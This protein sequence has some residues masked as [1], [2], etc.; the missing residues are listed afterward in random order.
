MLRKSLAMVLALITVSPAVAADVK[1]SSTLAGSP[2][3]DPDGAGMASF[4]IDAASGKVCYTLEVS[5]IDTA[6]A[7]HIHK[8]A[9]G[10][11]GPPVVPLDAPAN[12]K[13]Q[14]CAT[15]SPDVAAAIVADPSGYYVNVHNKAFMGGAIRGQLSK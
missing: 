8:G 12:G 3:T 5:N 13:S 1:L 14:G 10:A 6:L 4:T 7:A 11:G 2:T 15:V 9:A